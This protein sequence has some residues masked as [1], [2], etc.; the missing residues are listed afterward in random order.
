MIPDPLG[1]S[2]LADATLA[3]TLFAVD[4]PGLGG[5]VIRGPPGPVRD[6]WLSMTA[7]F[8]ETGAPIRRLPCHIGDDRLLG[9]LDLAATL[10]AGKAVVMR[11]LLAACDGGVLIVP[12]AE[13]LDAG[14]AARLAT[15]VDDHEICL[16]RDGFASRWPAR[17]GIVA[18]DEGL[19]PEE[20]TPPALL[21]R[22]A[23]N[24]DL[25]AADGRWIFQPDFDAAGV[26]RARSLLARF[27]T[28]D[29]AIVEA[30]CATAS[31]LGVQ[32][33]RAPI[34][35]LRAARAIAALNGRRGIEPHDAALAARLVLVP[36][37]TQ[38]PEDASTARE[39]DTDLSGSQPSPDNKDE[40]GATEQVAAPLHDTE[41]VIEAIKAALPEDLL[42]QI[43]F[44]ARAKAGGPGRRGNGALAKSARGGRPLGT[45]AGLPGPHARLS[46]IDTLRAAAPW[47]KLRR[48]EARSARLLIR[49]EDLHVRRFGQ[50]KQATTIFAVDASGSTAFQRLAEAKGAV[51]LLLAKAYVSRARV[52]LIAFRGTEAEVLLP[53]TRSL[54]R[55]KKQL[56]DLPGGGGTPL[57]AGITA[58]MR[59]ALYESARDQTPMIVFLSD[60]Q[61]NV[62]LNGRGGRAAAE[63]D[64]TL[65]CE[66]LRQSGIAA[67]FVDTSS[68]PR[69]DGDRFALAMGAVYA[70]LPYL[71]AQSVLNVVDAHRV[72]QA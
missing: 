46:L 54:T 24:I 21:D 25:A 43:R 16:E 70:P 34:L 45:W 47:Q 58:A 5:V 6:G 12:L 18:L 60:G 40:A 53:P 61:A 37:A 52:A 9:G 19:T 41:M 23:F 44:N 11:G 51:E 29:A 67:V 48:G 14:Q 42:A 3:A 35:A 7:S 69:S 39:D 26:A 27:E 15:V 56:S 72:R 22:L 49:R 59:M 65:A 63:H 8:F 62:D 13:R 2:S 30:L 38:L 50:R 1:P 66:Q 68:R 33:V 28:T 64:A 36:R 10:A 17:L 4:P 57:A 32:G 31:S 55:A 71:D 20:R